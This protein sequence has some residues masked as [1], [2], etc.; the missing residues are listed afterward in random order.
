[1]EKVVLLV[2]F[3][4][5]LLTDEVILI[6]CLPRSFNFVALNLVQGLLLRHVLDSSV[7]R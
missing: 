1:M 7:H 6:L 2:Y 4:D 3:A 5:E